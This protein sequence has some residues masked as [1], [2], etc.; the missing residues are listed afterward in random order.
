MFEP[1][2]TTCFWIPACAGMTG[3][4]CNGV[5]AGLKPASTDV[6]AGR[7]EGRS[8]SALFL[9]PQSAR[10]GR[11]RRNEGPRGLKGWG[12]TRAGHE[13]YV[14][15]QAKLR[16]VTDS[17]ARRRGVESNHNTSL[18]SEDTPLLSQESPHKWAF[19]F[20][21][22]PS[23]LSWREGS[24]KFGLVLAAHLG[25]RDFL[26]PRRVPRLGLNPQPI[27]CGTGQWQTVHTE[28]WLKH[29]E[30]LKSSLPSARH[31]AITAYLRAWR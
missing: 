31:F 11:L 4:I 20:V 7:A 15:F 22:L 30:H 10:G 23:G 21:G 8:P 3:A 28:S 29:I 24:R 18:L 16:G 9:F 14:S 13:R 19:F 26:T 17:P 12:L 27:L 2:A 6:A 1:A 25:I 5:Q